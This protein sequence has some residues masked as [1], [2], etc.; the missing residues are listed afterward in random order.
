MWID[1]RPHIESNNSTASSPLALD[2][3]PHLSPRSTDQPDAGS[4][5]CLLTGSMRRATWS[6]AVVGDEIEFEG[7]GA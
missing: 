7:A 5:L 6:V 3:N 4:S 1:L 2:N